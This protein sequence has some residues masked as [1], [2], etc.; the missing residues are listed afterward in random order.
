VVGMSGVGCRGFA[1][2][3]GW[4]L[5]FGSRRGGGVVG[6]GCR[7]FAVA[8]GLTVA[9]VLVRLVVPWVAVGHGLPWVLGSTV[10]RK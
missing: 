2:G 5:G 4:V 10:K 1:V 3:L 6:M 7:G 9:W 8:F